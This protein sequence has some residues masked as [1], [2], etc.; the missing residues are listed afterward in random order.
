MAASA[1]AL[2]MKPSTMTGDARLRRAQNRAGHHGDF[3]TAELGQHGER[4]GG[5]GAGGG[6]RQ[7]RLFAR[8]AGCVM[9]GAEADAGFERGGGEAVHDQRG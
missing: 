7:R 9:A 6:A 5:V 2:A 1:A 3:E 8:E 4:V